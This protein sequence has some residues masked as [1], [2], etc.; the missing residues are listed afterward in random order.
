VTAAVAAG[1][2]TLCCTFLLVPGHDVSIRRLG[3]LRTAEPVDPRV[4]LSAATSRLA[5]P[6]GGAGLAAA[7]SWDGPRSAFIAAA[8]LAAL[9]VTRKIVRESR[10]REARRRRQR[11]VTTLC[12]ALSAE[13][14]AGLPALTAVVRS[15]QETPELTSVSTAARLGGDIASALHRCAGAP[16]AEG[17]RAVAAAWEVAGSSGA[18]LA[19]VLARVAGSLR[20]D[21]D[22]R[23]EVQAA[24]GPPRATAKM[25]AVLP[26]FG[27]ALGSSMGARPVHF[28]VAT[29]WGFGCLSSGGMLALMGVW[30]VERLASSAEL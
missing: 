17:L 21:E 4:S 15:C 18:G 23:A 7:L 20:S 29:S 24:L 5:F 25:L 2:V 13:L 12:D 1:L 11:A 30:W 16:G 14:R 22:A 8:G 6:V 19:A 9:A 26:L 3:E 10:L 28:L 27:V